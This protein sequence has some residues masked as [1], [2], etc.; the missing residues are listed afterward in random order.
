MSVEKMRK[1][2]KPRDVV[3]R[4]VHNDCHALLYKVNKKKGNNQRN[5]NEG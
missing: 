3:D 1:N 2:S 5:L 4:V